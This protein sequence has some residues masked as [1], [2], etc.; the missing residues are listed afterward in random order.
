M[1]PSIEFKFQLEKGSRKYLCP[2]C[3]KRRFVRYINIETKDYLPEQYGRCDREQSCNYH[4]KPGKEQKQ[5]VQKYEVPK[6]VYIPEEVFKPT[7]RAYEQNSFIK[8]LL[9]L[10]DAQ[11]VTA[12]VE[13]YHLGT[14]LRGCIFW[15]IDHVGNVNAGMIKQFDETGH[16]VED[17]ETWVNKIPALQKQPWASEYNNQE[18]KVNCLYGAHLLK[19]F[20]QMPIALCEAPK[21]AIIAS[22]YFPAFI[23]M[24]AF[25]KSSLADYK[26]YILKGRNVTL[27]PDLGAF[28]EWKGYGDAHGFYTNEALEK[29]ATDEE[30]NRGLD[31]ADYITR[32][33]V[34]QFRESPN[35][36]YIEKLKDGREIL[37]HPKG[38]PA[39]WDPST[40]TK[41]NQL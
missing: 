37:M 7:R 26:T 20:P 22:V 35:E 30:R 6:R 24:A 23:W 15:F 39:T 36:Y 10:F 32:Y 34:E 2:S 38:Y 11:T 16:T 14:S 19:L 25:N 33:S 4:L 31:L 27:F 3:G 12:L 29:I 1:I 8:Y 9:T 17:S 5:P 41:Q 40:W 18:R 13:R 28:D 21:T